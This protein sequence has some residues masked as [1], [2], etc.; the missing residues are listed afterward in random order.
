MNRVVCAIM[1]II[2]WDFLM[3]DQTF[4][5]P[6]VKQSAIISNKHGIIDLPHEFP[7]DLRLKSY[8]LTT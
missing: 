2:F 7:Y 3:F 5:S 8:N 6:Q 4:L 1:V